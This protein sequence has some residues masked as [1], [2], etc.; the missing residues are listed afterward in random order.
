MQVESLVNVEIKWKRLRYWEDKSVGY[1]PEMP[2]PQSGHGNKTAASTRRVQAW[3]GQAEAECP[4]SCSA[5]RRVM[6]PRASGQ[7]CDVSM[8]EL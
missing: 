6:V 2:R 7:H 5:P 4:R 3:G 1:G 8:L